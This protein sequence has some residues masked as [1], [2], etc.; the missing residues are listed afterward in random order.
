M[1][2]STYM[3]C[4][5]FLGLACADRLAVCAAGQVWAQV[6]VRPVKVSRYV[7]LWARASG[8]ELTSEALE[9]SLRLW[10]LGLQLVQD[11]EAEDQC[12]KSL[13]RDCRDW[14]CLVPCDNGYQMDSVSGC[15][16]CTCAPASAVEP[17][18]PGKAGAEAKPAGFAPHMSGSAGAGNCNRMRCLVPCEGGYEVDAEGCPTCVCS[19]SSSGSGDANKPS[20]PKSLVPENAATG[21]KDVSSGASRNM[22]KLHSWPLQ[23]LRAMGLKSA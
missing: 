23:L 10:G 13:S 14:R 22:A 9:E 4:G 7:S 21:A 20:G 12:I 8:L 17:T 19:S 6:Q 11:V 5:V 15:L 3:L 2:M 18:V 1:A 16:T